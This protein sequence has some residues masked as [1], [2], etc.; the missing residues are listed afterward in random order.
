VSI[1]GYLSYI[2]FQPEY[3][4]QWWGREDIKDSG[5]GKMDITGRE[6][7]GFDYEK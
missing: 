7:S 2:H 4:S 1:D 3:L 5:E 6:N